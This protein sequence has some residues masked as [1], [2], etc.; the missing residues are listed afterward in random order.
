MFKPLTPSYTIESVTLTFKLCMISHVLPLKW[1]L[2]GRPQRENLLFANFCLAL[3]RS[4]S[5]N[6]IMTYLQGE[7]HIL[8][9][10]GRSSVPPKILLMNND[11]LKNESVSRSRNLYKIQIGIP[12]C[13][14]SC[15]YFTRT[16]SDIYIKFRETEL[17]EIW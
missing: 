3:T 7:N 15:E 12:T 14:M 11:Y 16:L 9:S 10:Q 1:N 5:V 4:E 17:V 8:N 6:V 13:I 2:F